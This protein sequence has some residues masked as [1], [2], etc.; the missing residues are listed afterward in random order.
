[1]T[2]ARASVD[3]AQSFVEMRVA[4]SNY[5]L[6]NNRR[7]QRLKDFQS[8]KRNAYTDAFNCLRGFSEYCD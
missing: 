1:M 5:V 4:D 3:L 6:N 7:Q 8:R 2:P